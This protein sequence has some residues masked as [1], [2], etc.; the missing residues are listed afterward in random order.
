MSTTLDPGKTA[1]LQI[2]PQIAQAHETTKAH[3]LQAIRAA[4]NAGIPYR[5]IGEALGITEAGVRQ[6][7]RRAQ[8]ATK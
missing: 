7:L 5:Q 1:V 4:R 8:E 2:L 6:I 3:R